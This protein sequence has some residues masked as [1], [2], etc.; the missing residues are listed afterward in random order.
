MLALQNMAVPKDSGS[1]LA[2][3]T[4]HST[5]TMKSA[6]TFDAISSQILGLTTI[7][8]NLQKE[9]TQLSRRSKDNATDLVSLKEATNSRDEDIRKSLRDLA[10]NVTARI[11]EPGP[12]YGS[13][14]ASNYSR[15]PGNF[16]LDSKPHN[17][18]PGMPKSYSLPRLGSPGLTGSELSTSSYNIEAPASIALLEKI[19]RDMGTKEGQGQL[20]VALTELKD[21]PK[22]S[23]SDPSIVKKLEEI[24]GFVKDSTGSRALVTRRDNGNGGGNRAPSFSLDFD[25]KPAPLSRSSREL[26][27]QREAPQQNVNPAAATFVNEDLQKLLKKMK[28]SITEGGG[29][30]AEVKAHL[31]DLRG[32]VLG[33]GRDIARKLDQAESTSQANRGDAHGPG[34]EE[35]AQIV[36]DGLDE[37]RNQMEELVREKRRQSSASVASRHSV[38]SQ[39][40]YTAV[41]NALTEFPLQQQVALQHAGP[42]IEREEILEAVR[43]AWETYKPEI[44]LQ[45]FGLERDE[46]L[47]CLK[48]GLK[49]CQPHDQD[50]EKGGVSYDEVLDAVRE[51]LQDFRPP[52]IETE[53]SITREEILE[54]VREC[55]ETFEFPVPSVVAPRELEITRGDVLDAVKEGLSTQAPI[56]KE[57]EFNREDLFDAVKAG[58]EGARTPMGGVGEKVL[59]KMEDLIDGMRVEFKQY[60]VANG[61]DTEQVLDAMKDGL[62]VL[63]ADIESYVDRA[64]DVTGKDEIIDTVRHGLDHLRVDLEGSI[65]NNSHPSAPTNSSELL[66]A[67]EKEFEHLR[68]TIATSMIRSGDQGLERE[69]VLDVIREGLGNVNNSVSR[70]VRSDTNEEILNFMREEFEH[71]RE[72]LSSTIVRGGPS[73]DRD[74]MLDAI[75]EGHESLRADLLAKHDRPESIL[76]GT[77]EILDALNEGLDGIRA[78][79]EKVVT[80][81]VDM[82]VNYEILETL[83]EGLANVRADVDRLHTTQGRSRGFSTAGEGEVIIAENDGEGLHRNDIGNLEMMI[84]QLRIK[85]EALDNM[86]PPPTSY[87]AEGLV[88]K[89]H[90]EGLE[91]MLRD[92]QS[93]VTDI[94]QKEHYQNENTVTKDDTEAI[95]TLLRNT[96]AK[97]DEFTSS[98]SESI[99]KVSHIESLESMINDTHDTLHDLGSDSASKKDVSVLEALLKEVRAGLEE[100]REK[101][102]GTDDGDRVGKTDIEALETLCMDTKTQIAELPLPDVDTIP[103]K[104]EFIV[105]A[106]LVRRFH[107]EVSEERSLTAQAFEA[108][109]IEHGGLADKMEDVKLIFEDVREELKAKIKEGNH[110]VKDLAKSLELVGET[111]TASDSTGTVNE[112]VEIVKREFQSLHTA[113]ENI[114]E[115]SESN[116]AILLGKHAEHKDAIVSDLNAKLDTRFDEIMTK[117]D[118]AQ[119]AAQEKERA[120][121]GK[122]SEQ[123]ATLSATKAAAE[124]LRLLVD[125]L[126]STVTES[127]DRMSEDSKTVFNRVEEVGLR[128][129]DLLASDGKA[130]HQKTRADVSKVL[131]SV[132]GIQAHTKEYQP[133]ILEAVKDV[134]GMVGQ[135]YEQ[136]RTSTEEIKTSV[137]AIPG[138]IPLPAIAPSNP[139]TELFREAPV[140]EKYDDTTIH[141]KLDELIGH[142]TD[143]GKSIAEVAML[144]QLREQVAATSTQLNGVAAAQQ[145]AITETKD[146]RAKEA[147]EAAIALEKRNAQKSIVEA[148]IMRLSDDKAGLSNDVQKLL[149]EKDELASL[150]S[151][152]Q[153]D[154]S[155]LE[156]AL[157]IRREELHIMEARAD[158]L[159]RRIL[160]GVLDHSR[161]LLTTSRPQ[162]SLK[163]MNLKRVASTASNVTATTRAST[164]T[165]VP[166]LNPSAVSSGVGMALKRRQA[167]RTSATFTTGKTDRRILS[168]STLGANKGAAAERSIVLA[169]P[170]V[171]SGITRASGAGAGSMKRS[172]SV[173]S[174]FPHRKTSWGG[175][176]AL[177]MHADD[178]ADDGEDKENSV[179]DEEDE[180]NVEGSEAGTERR[181]SYGTYTGTGSYGEGSVVS[182]GDKRISY[183][184]ST[185]GTVGTKDF[186]VT[187]D[188]E[189]EP[190]HE[191]DEE[192]EEENDGLYVPKEAYQGDTAAKGG[193]SNAGEMIVFGQPSDSGIGTDP[194]TAQL[195]GGID[196]F[197][198]V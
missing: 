88:S 86:P 72:T 112:L 140:Y 189:S 75:R 124:D 120:L 84:T 104:A 89:E 85:V 133:K 68:Q 197:K 148:D 53:A 24:L 121:G 127:C 74:E 12:D 126:G 161:S 54:S 111:V 131:A 139:T 63:R 180:G 62:E 44:E 193:I 73:G 185:I 170:S 87:A 92:V 39:E 152:M 47:E 142:A 169:N 191:A 196:Y 81:P 13:R 114:K 164:G 61:G 113:S 38:D 166:S 64:A 146:T 115:H 93:A 23:K 15:S 6:Q 175:T 100:L 155:S 158:G 94:V 9:M 18:E 98:K 103:T 123:K 69:E 17:F 10:Q 8:T 186:A 101:G 33:M 160:D 28:D 159:E 178:G 80:R 125:T 29:I 149:K 70:D 147:E 163:E 71:L 151:K 150:K 129:D 52:P 41:K 76:S 154:L 105:L 108:R 59:D 182:N 55:L 3:V 96:K 143:A 177:G 181:T 176:K 22:L 110:S 78:D 43:E 141:S 106:D 194:P 31:R 144:E 130:E 174:N 117:Y 37:L 14:A 122:D 11:H 95:E 97:I 1:S 109:K 26:T 165:T 157:Q 42:G 83:K 49:Q 77:G 25:P 2:D 172:H 198:R 195:E 60:S 192:M 119:L 134:L 5:P 45:N 137:Q 184:A 32:E 7:A 66:D 183:D 27:P 102:P 156:T 145:A 82:T 4:N 162:S 16:L 132:E 51:G 188:G 136:S 128:L 168:L 171:A 35:I 187:E 153:A 90:I 48:E 57:I 65:S 34:R 30:T 21:Q 79:V 58:L 99:A 190:E 116:H 46:I 179:L 36:Q 107:E 50:H 19:W 167:P 67:M 138:S 40:V 135:H 91:A 56:S 118:D 173:K 20:V